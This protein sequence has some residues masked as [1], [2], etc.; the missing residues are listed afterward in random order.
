MKQTVFEIATERMVTLLEQGTN[1]WRKP[2][3]TGSGLEPMNY[4]SKKPYRGIN[5]FLLSMV[6]NPYFLSFKQLSAKGGT[7]KKGTKSHIVFFW[8]WTY[9]DAKGRRT[10]DEKQAVKKIP[11]LRY[12]RVFNALDIEGIDFEYPEPP[13]L[14]PN[15]KIENCENLVCSTGARI[16]H[17]E[18]QAYYSPVLDLVNMPPIETFENSAFYYS[19]LFHELGH[20]TG[21]KKRLD[22][23]MT[24]RNGNEKYSKEEL[25][26]EMTAA[27]LCAE[28]GID[29]DDLTMN[30]AAYLKG[31][32]TALKGDTKLLITAASAAQKA[33]KFLTQN[34]KELELTS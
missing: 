22:R 14:K 4:Q 21:G 13:E 18:P 29:N 17:R 5:F 6:E 10:K 26:A 30:S 16:T 25:I 33:H 24:G 9:L 27:F 23:D 11:N 1:P 7:V 34:I 2:W 8:L 28:M 12:Y 15:Q 32:I 20:W 19:V 3:S 31:W